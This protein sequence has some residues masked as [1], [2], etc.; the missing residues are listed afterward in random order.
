MPPRRMRIAA[1]CPACQEQTVDYTAAELDLPYFGDM[2]QTVFICSSCGFRHSDVIH[3]RTHEPRRWTYRA[4]GESDMTVRVV[5]STS[6]T[7][8]IPELG[9]VIEPGPASEA[10]VSNIE[11]VLDRIEAVLRQLHRDA[12]TEPERDACRERLEHVARARG[13]REPITLILEDPLGNSLI[14]H[15]AATVE[16]IPEAEAAN[17]PRGEISFDVGGAAGDGD[18]APGP[19]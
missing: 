3:G 16:A 13:G 9:V 12:D 4:S 19:S 8:R 11:G 6:G 15:E 7:V 1:P 17:L 14:A 10:F 18:G 2:L 5:R